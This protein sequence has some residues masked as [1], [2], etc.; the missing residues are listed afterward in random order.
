MKLMKSHAL[1]LFIALTALAFSPGVDVRA[2]AQSAP[3][4]DIRP[5]QNEASAANP[6]I[7]PLAFPTTGDCGFP[8]DA[9]DIRAKVGEV[10]KAH[11]AATT[12]AIGPCAPPYETP[13]YTKPADDSVAF[14]SL[15]E[16]S[17][18]SAINGSSWIGL[19]AGNYCGGSQKQLIVAQNKSPYFSVLNGPTP[20]HR[21]S[22]GTASLG[23]DESDPWRAVTSGKIDGTGVDSL[24]AVRHVT[25]SGVPDVVVANVDACNCVA[26]QGVAG[27]CETPTVFTTDTIGTPEDSDWVGAVVGNFDGSGKSIALLKNGEFNMYLLKLEEPSNK[28]N[29]VYRTALARDGNASSKWKALAAADIDGDGIDELIVARQEE[30]NSSATVLAYKYDPRTHLFYVKASS[31]FGNYGNSDWVGAAGGDFNADG[32]QAV[33][34]V[35]NE[36]SYFSLMDF[37]KG[38]T[39]LRVLTANDLDSVAGQP[40]TGVTATDWLHGDDGASEVIAVRSVHGAN[41]TNL[42]VYGNPFHRTSRDTGT[43]GTKAQWSAINPNLGT[44]LAGNWSSTSTGDLKSWMRSTH[45]NTFLWLLTSPGDYTH[46]VELLHDTKDWG[47]DGRALR[48][49]LTV[50]NPHVVNRTDV[51]CAQPEATPELTSWNALSYFFADRQAGA[52]PQDKVMN[53]C[54][55]MA[56]WANVTGRLAKDYPQLVGMGI[57]DFVDYQ[58]ADF[59]PDL[60]A[61][62]ESN[63][64]S[65]APWLNFSPFLYYPAGSDSWLTKW[66]DLGMALDSPVFFFR[67]EKR[68]VCIGPPWCDQTVNNAPDEISDMSHLLPSGRKMLLGVYYV[69]LWTQPKLNRGIQ[70]TPSYDYNLTTLGLN[71]ELVGSAVAYGLIVPNP[72]VTCTA[73]NYLTDT[74]CALTAA[75]GG[76]PAPTLLLNLSANSLVFASEYTGEEESQTLTFTNPGT[77]DVTVTV[78]PSLTPQQAAFTWTGG[79]FT[80]APGASQTIDVS[81]WAKTVGRVGQQLSIYSNAIGSPFVVSLYGTGVKGDPR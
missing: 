32:R 38:A 10:T 72:D 24:V 69:G 7:V 61:E 21:L 28:L 42:F 43:G 5:N 54:R 68:G 19:A 56:A 51:D 23:S 31:G 36:T 22:D 37:P 60:I 8:E 40:W 74:A 47:V 52:T 58:F 46:L 9:E 50:A 3:S 26:E 63:M 17:G 75:Y 4:R 35:K 15:L 73:A 78:P 62:M 6:N 29:V 45:T 34:L 41:K 64:R 30:D 12:E 49:W 27:N 39:E 80:L 66:A 76:P 79:T 59:S 1:L 57:D 33:V 71:S 11:P 55:D 18:Y 77:G 13:V 16:A 14:G 65:Q 53:E 48:I 81:F 20:Y 44:G 67:N 2:V 70:P 25:S